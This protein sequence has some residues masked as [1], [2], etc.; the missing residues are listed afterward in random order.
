MTEVPDAFLDAFFGPGNSVWTGR[1]A[2]STWATFVERFV[3]SAKVGGQSPLILPRRKVSGSPLIAYILC[4]DRAQSDQM[5]VTLEAFVAHSFAKVDP[6]TAVLDPQDSVEESVINF[7]GSESTYVISP[8]PDSEKEFWQALL[9]LK[10]TMDSRPERRAELPRSLGRLLADFYGALATGQASAS[11]DL[12]DQ[13]ATAG[14]SYVNLAHLRIMRLSRLGK[15]RELLAL[16]ELS[17]VGLSEPP[18]PVRDAIL[19]AWGRSYVGSDLGKP[20]VLDLA[21]SRR[22]SGERLPGVDVDELQYLSDDALKCVAVTA[23]CTSDQ[24]LAFGIRACA[25]SLGDVAVARLSVKFGTTSDAPQAFTEMVVSPPDRLSPDG[26]AAGFG[27]SKAITPTSWSEW[28]QS[29]NSNDAALLDEVNWPEWPPPANCDRELAEVLESAGSEQTWAMVGPFLEADDLSTP[30]W[31]SA[32]ELLTQALVYERF[33]SAELGTIEALLETF[34]RGAPPTGQYTEILSLL[35]ETGNR[36]ATINNR[37]QVLD[38]ADVL[39][40]GPKPDRGAALSMG[41]VLLAEIHAHKRRLS[42]EL[43]WLAEQVSSELG[44]T[45]DWTLP[46]PGPGDDSVVRRD[47]GA[48]TILLYSLDEGVL[49]RSKV[50]CKVLAP[51]AKVHLNS[52]KVGSDRL[53]QQT[54]N[55][56]VVVIATRCATHAATGFISQHTAR[57][58]IVV[59]AD[60][61]GSASLIRAIE[62]GL[63]LAS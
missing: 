2:A 40:R 55:A 52:D 45:W 18:L 8:E 46:G 20:E 1:D 38:I 44:L 24:D 14:L 12:L 9:N 25:E 26:E 62:S 16:P 29:I 13:L 50:A 59:E 36:W 49:Q 15:D 4:W 23:I 41:S 37:M 19:A 51:Q 60:G 63:A 57:D 5:R 31:R 7:V 21:I 6:R 32:R 53:R 35:A 34:L 58:A 42:R 43:F 10:L 30:A 11:D 17:D 39:A 56:D 33:G 61:A 22:G 54:R 48:K 47:V 3:D 27:S 28:A